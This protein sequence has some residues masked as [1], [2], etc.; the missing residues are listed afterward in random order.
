MEGPGVYV[1]QVK[2]DLNCQIDLEF[3]SVVDK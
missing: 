3:Q 2:F 1:L